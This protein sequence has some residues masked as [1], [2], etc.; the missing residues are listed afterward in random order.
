MPRMLR[1]LLSAGVVGLLLESLVPFSGALAQ[2]VSDAERSHAPFVFNG[3]TWP[4]QQAFIDSGGRCG[5]RSVDPTEA[6]SIEEALQ[7][8]NAGLSPEVLERAPGSVLVNVYFHVITDAN[9]VGNLEDASIVAQ[10][11]VLNAA[12]DG[13]TG[14]T[15]TPFRF[16]LVAVD[17]TANAAWFTAGP[18]TPA[19]QEMK[20]ALHRGTAKDLN[21]YTNTPPQLLGWATVPWDYA[22]APLD[23]G[24]VILYASLP[25]GAAAPYN[26]GYTAVHEVGHWLG[27]F[28]TF[29]GGCF[30]LGD[31]V[32]D[33]PAESS[34]AFGC[35]TGRDSCPRRAGADPINDFM[36]YTDDAC[37]FYFT[38]GQSA[39]ADSLVL[40]YRGL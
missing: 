5:T 4:N 38:S 32:P 14:G 40:Q 8:F 26:L 18:G 2:D 19:E 33:T 34:A 35:P 10:I 15:N 24:V 28:H 13:T 31:H 3:F 12:Y 22:N 27:L 17:R 29:Q 16:A 9:G 39:R 23:D 21:L 30:P 11:A 20:T 1:V 37:M 7:R 36:D 6:R 25:G